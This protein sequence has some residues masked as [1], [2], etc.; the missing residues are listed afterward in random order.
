MVL[1][2]KILDA[3]YEANLEFSGGIGVQNKKPSTWGVCIFSAFAHC[4]H[5]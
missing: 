3:K 2:V 4:S 1:K 5:K